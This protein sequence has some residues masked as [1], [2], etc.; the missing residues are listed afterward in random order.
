LT[1][2]VS[3][4]GAYQTNFG[5]AREHAITVMTLQE[6]NDR[7]LV[8]LQYSEQAVLEDVK[9]AIITPSDAAA[10]DAGTLAER[11]R[12][13]RASREKPKPDETFGRVGIAKQRRRG[14]RAGK[15]KNPC[16]QVGRAGL[17]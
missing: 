16:G 1:V 13:L 7:V 14:S 2:A 5:C 10:I 9:W 15:Q 12:R 3:Q 8:W 6:E 17:E 4:K 11:V